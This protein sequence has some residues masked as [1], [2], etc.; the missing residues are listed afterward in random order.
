M[1]TNAD[2]IRLKSDEELARFLDETQRQECEDLHEV[3]PDGSLKCES[4]K[5]GWL[6]WL[7]KEAKAMKACNS[8]A[9]YIAAEG[10]TP[11]AGHT[12]A[13]SGYIS[14]DNCA[15]RLPCG[16]CR[17]INEP[18]PMRQVVHGE[19]TCSNTEVK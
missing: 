11:T 13:A 10:Y 1:I 2:C 5:R 19:V 12:V 14:A 3:N 8:N 15:Y 9:N 18:C 7:K 6:I 4:C 17:E 16:L